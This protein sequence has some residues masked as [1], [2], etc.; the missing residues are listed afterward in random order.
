MLCPTT[1]PRLEARLTRGPRQ[2]QRSPQTSV[3]HRFVAA[4][5]LV[6]ALGALLVVSSPAQEARAEGARPTASVNA[7]PSVVRVG[8]S[9]AAAEKMLETRLRRLLELEL[10]RSVTLAASSIG[11]LDENALRVWVDLAGPTLVLVQV[12]APG[13]R[14]ELRRVDVAGLSWDVA[15]RFVALA[16]SESVR[17]QLAPVVRKRPRPPSAAEILAAEASRSTVQTSA[18]FVGGWLEPASAALFGSRL[19][20][21]FHGAPLGQQL[22]L[23]ALGG[24]SGGHW[25]ELGTGA[26]HRRWLSRALRVEL[27]GGLGLAA[28]EGLSGPGLRPESAVYARASARAG[29]EARL[30]GPSWAALR[31]EPGVVFDAQREEAGAWL[32]GSLAILLDAPVSPATRPQP[33]A[34]SAR[35]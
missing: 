32:G 18:A 13:K 21:A 23:S 8:L 5:R 3:G 6:A 33:S 9:E 12:Q 28:T 20:L 15:A 26:T 17:S 22:S 16:A 10:P 34:A 4:Q 7:A 25:L 11:P 29:L 14:V 31:V 24:T 35:R 19:E 1:A 30:D 2:L 27:G